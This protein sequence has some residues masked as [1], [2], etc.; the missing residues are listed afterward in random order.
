MLE[1][2]VLSFLFAVVLSPVCRWAYKQGRF[3]RRSIDDIADFLHK[4]NDTSLMMALDPA[5]QEWLR[6]NKIFYRRNVRVLLDRLRRSL[7][8]VIENVTVVG[9]WARTEDIDR[10]RLGVEYNRE[11]RELLRELIRGC[12]E[13]HQ[14]MRMPQI[15]I[16]FWGFL[17]FEE[18]DF[19]PIPNVANIGRK[20][21]V[22]LLERYLCIREMTVRL[23][24]L[25]YPVAA[26]SI[27]EKI[28]AL[29]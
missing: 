13:F 3:K 2:L 7:H 11:V 17:H 23:V 26:P 21:D 4:C 5:E 19:L 10:A 24:T 18:W 28:N 14:A 22:T 29:M 9:D 27:C 12:G 6:A 25:M 20:G 16:W 15:K 8:P 1:C